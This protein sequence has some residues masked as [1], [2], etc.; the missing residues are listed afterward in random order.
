MNKSPNYSGTAARVSDDRPLEE[1]PEKILALIDWIFFGV[2]TSRN[3]P[4]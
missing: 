3:R 4:S 1:D 2:D